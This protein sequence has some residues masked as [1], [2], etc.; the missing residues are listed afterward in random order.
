MK[1]RQQGDA[2]RAELLAG[3]PDDIRPRRAG[4][5]LK[6]QI[7]FRGAAGRA[8]ARDAAWHARV[9]I[10]D[11]EGEALN[12]SPAHFRRPMARPQPEKRASR[13][14]VDKRGDD[15]CGGQI[16]DKNRQ[17]RDVGLFSASEQFDNIGT[18]KQS[19]HPVERHRAGC[20]DHRAHPA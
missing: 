9:A 1:C 3:R 11:R 15:A 14:S 16:R 2:A 20:I 7:G 8:D 19:R 4:D 17:I 5:G 10:G 13:V 18:G 6:Q 12:A